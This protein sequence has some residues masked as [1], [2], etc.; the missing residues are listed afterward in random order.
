MSDTIDR[1]VRILD[2]VREERAREK[3]RADKNAQGHWQAER[4]SQRLATE[5]DAALEVERHVRIERANAELKID[6]WVKYAH[7]LVALIPMAWRKQVPKPP[8]RLDVE[9]PF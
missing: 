8:K 7:A 5:R 1:L 2:E 6:E 4:T 3:E 9:I